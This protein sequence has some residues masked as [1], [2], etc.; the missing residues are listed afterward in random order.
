M[1]HIAHSC[2]ALLTGS[3][4]G[5]RFWKSDPDKILST[6]EMIDYFINLIDQFPIVS[7]EDPLDQN[8]WT[9]YTALTEAIGVI[10]P[11]KCC[12]AP[13]TRVGG[14]AQSRLDVVHVGDIGNGA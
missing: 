2:F 5:Y 3:R 1:S 9:G 11:R 8:D 10:W 4:Q 14:M 6:S 7:I 13:E 12:E